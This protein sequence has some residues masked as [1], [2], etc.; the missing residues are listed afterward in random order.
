MLHTKFRRNRHSGFWKDFGNVLS[1][2]GHG[3]HLGHVTIVVLVNDCFLLPTCKRLHTKCGKIVGFSEKQ[4][5]IF[6]CK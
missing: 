3:S 2:N 6:I 4:V 5:Q 1:I